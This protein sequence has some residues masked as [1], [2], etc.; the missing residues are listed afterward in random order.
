[1]LSVVLPL[2]A[3]ELE[4]LTLL[5]EQGEIVSELLTGDDRLKAIIGSHPGLR[6]KAL[7]VKKHHGI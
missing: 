6:W 3:E 2:T 1:M 5:N 7:N 4:F